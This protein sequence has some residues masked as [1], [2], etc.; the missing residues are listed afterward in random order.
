[1]DIKSKSWLWLFQSEEEVIDLKWWM[2]KL[3]NKRLTGQDLQVRSRLTGLAGDLSTIAIKWTC[4]G[5]LYLHLKLHFGV[6]TPIRDFTDY[7]PLFII[8]CSANTTLLKGAG[9]GGLED[10]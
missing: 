7:F 4:Q 2:A 1:M 5:V 10:S 6:V 3:H 9:G 8:W